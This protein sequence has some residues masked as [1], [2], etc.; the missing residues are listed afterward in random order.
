MDTVTR[1]SPPRPPAVVVMCVVGLYVATMVLIA[2][3]VTHPPVLGW[4]GLGVLAVALAAATGLGMHL[5]SGQR[6]NAVRLHPHDGTI[7]RL[8][9][10]L[11]SDVEP[12]ELRTA[13]ELRAVG[14]SLEVRL[15]APTMPATTLHY[16]TGDEIPERHVATRRLGAALDTLEAS[17][18]RASGQI[19]TDDPLQAAA[20]AL[21]SWPADEILFVTPVASR[22]TWLERDLER[23]ARDALG[24]PV[25]T[26]FGRTVPLARA[27]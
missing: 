8:L 24:L 26:V 18:I 3:F 27:A 16:L 25:E 5:L 21:V 20:D 13:I 11:D 10:V 19:G 4:I 9:V 2:L 12:D 6:V 17:G 14:R 1:K 22:R 7:H 15:V 23:R